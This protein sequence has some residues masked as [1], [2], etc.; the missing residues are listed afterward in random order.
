MTTVGIVTGV[1]IGCVLLLWAV[2]LIRQDR[3]YAGYGVIFVFGTIGAMVVLVVPPLL[4]IATAVS[5]AVLP[6]PSLSLLVLVILTF[7]MVYVFVQ[8]SVLSN[9]VMKLTQELAIQ[10]PERQQSVEGAAARP[11]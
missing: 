3:L 11:R 4:R 5:V 6:V 8:I 9:L 7:L 2:I 1:A 10:S